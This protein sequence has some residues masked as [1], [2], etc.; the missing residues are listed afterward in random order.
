[1][2]RLQHLKFVETKTTPCKICT[3]TH[4]RLFPSELSGRDENG[5]KMGKGKSDEP[6]DVLLK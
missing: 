5:S 3:Y 2:H 4:L 1:M 6:M